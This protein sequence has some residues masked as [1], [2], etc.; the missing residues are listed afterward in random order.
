[1]HG[2]RIIRSLW[3]YFKVTNVIANNLFTK[4]PS[5][6]AAAT[7]VKEKGFSMIRLQ[8]IAQQRDIFSSLE[9]LNSQPEDEND[10]EANNENRGRRRNRSVKY[11]MPSPIRIIGIRSRRENKSDHEENSQ[12]STPLPSPLRFRRGS[13][14]LGRQSRD[15]N[16]S[17]AS[18][19]LCVRGTSP[20]QK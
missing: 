16:N 1:M 18:A 14:S 9:S 13:H 19:D 11:S 7:E 4:M 12:P 6:M 8:H 3:E 17:E 20:F 5:L 15:R 2:R 10:T